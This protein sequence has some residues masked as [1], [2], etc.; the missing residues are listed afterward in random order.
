MEF[1]FKIIMSGESRPFQGY[2]RHFK[3]FDKKRSQH[4][5]DGYL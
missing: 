3:D 5:I 4:E 2:W 1:N